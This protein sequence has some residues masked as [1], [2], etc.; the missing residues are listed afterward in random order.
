LLGL[1]YTNY[2]NKNILFNNSALN[3]FKERSF[4]SVK[5]LIKS[6]SIFYIL[7]LVCIVFSSCSVKKEHDLINDQ[8]YKVEHEKEQVIPQE[9][10]SD[11]NLQDN[12][13]NTSD[14]KTK[15]EEDDLPAENYGNKNNLSKDFLQNFY[16]FTEQTFAHIIRDNK[17]K[18]QIYAPFNFYLSLSILNELSEEDA[19][20]EIQNALNISDAKDHA[21]DLNTALSSLQERKFPIELSIDRHNINT[22]LW[23]SDKINYQ[24]N[25]L[26]MLQSQYNTEIFRGDL[27]DREFQNLMAKWVYENTNFEFQP[28][29]HKSL[30]QID[31]YA[32]ISLSTLDFYDEW[33]NPFNEEDTRPDTFFISDNEKITCDFMNMEERDH[34]FMVGED[35]ISTVCV[36]KG[37]ESMLFILPEE[38]LSVD[39]FIGEKGKLSEIIYGWTDEEAPVKKVSAGKVKLSVPKFAYENEI[40]LKETAEK[41]GIKKIFDKNSRAFSSFADEDIYLTDI[42]QASKIEINEKGCS[43]SSYTEIFAFGSSGP[44]DD[45]AEIILNRP[46]IYI[47]YKN[48]VPFLAGVVRNPIG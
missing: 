32:F 39:D 40:D 30:D 7:I 21:S 47:L 41:M 35:F 11:K 14:I 10:L 9:D 45:E 28:D 5:K 48:K 33:L 4:K 25:L 38:G 29:Y 22:S 31:P 16:D 19:R 20:E 8:N 17:G 18:N 1:Q 15:I 6:Y 26:N 44:K 24:D 13:E 3:F 34:P 43:A 12:S 23:L 2:Y 42:S 36:L 27:K 46:F 37:H